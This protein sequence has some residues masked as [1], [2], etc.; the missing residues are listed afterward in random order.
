MFIDCD[1]TAGSSGGGWI[2]GTTLLSVTSYGYPSS[3]DHLYGP[4]M[5]RSAKSLYRKAGNKPKKKRRARA[6]SSRGGR[7]FGGARGGR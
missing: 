2:A 1:M 5:S 4:Y 7:R 6:G 3:S